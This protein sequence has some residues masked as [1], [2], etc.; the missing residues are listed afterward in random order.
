[1]VVVLGNGIMGLLS[2]RVPIWGRGWPDFITDWLNS[3]FGWIQLYFTFAGL[4]ALALGIAVMLGVRLEENFN[5]P[6]VAR[7]LVEFWTRWHMTLSLWCKD[8][9]FNPITALS[10]SPLVGICIAMLAIGIW[11]E[12]SLYYV[13]W[14]F[15]QALG[16]VLSRSIPSYFPAVVNHPKMQKAQPF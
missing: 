5:K 9:V 10:R 12:S 15:W 11:H 3:A 6:W 4:T 2:S 8:Y 16:I 7:N 1:M 13:L 14:S